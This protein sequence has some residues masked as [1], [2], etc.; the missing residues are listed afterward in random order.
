[1]EESKEPEKV[2]PTSVEEEE[3]CRTEEDREVK[4]NLKLDFTHI[5]NMSTQI[6]SGVCI[7]R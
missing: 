2:E 7:L 5:R 6:V 1:M 3:P 4:D